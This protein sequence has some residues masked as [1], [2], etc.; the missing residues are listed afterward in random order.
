MFF[1]IWVREKGAIVKLEE[2]KILFFTVFLKFIMPSFLD[3]IFEYSA[4][5]EELVKLWYYIC[6]N[7]QKLKKTL[8]D[9]ET[10]KANKLILEIGKIGYSV[11]EIFIFVSGS[12]K[13]YPSFIEF[14][15]P[16]PPEGVV[17]VRVGEDENLIDRNTLKTVIF[18]IMS[19]QKRKDTSKSK[20]ESSQKS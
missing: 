15:D 16:Y 2:H 3:F 4:D 9:K 20:K 6:S 7:M 13:N 19:F 5:L 11:S 17:R 1:L 8:A 14:N 18:K 10:F 12:L